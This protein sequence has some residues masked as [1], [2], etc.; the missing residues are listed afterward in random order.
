MNRKEKA[1]RHLN[2]NGQ[3]IEIGPGP[4][5]IAS[6]KEGY[7]V[8][9][10]DYLDRK[11]LITKFKEYHVNLDNIEEVD[12]IW[13]GENYAELTGKSKYYD[14][15]IAS[16]TIE[17]T[18]DLIDFLNDCDSI[19][20]DDGMIF[21]VI[22]DKRYCFDHYRPI[23][24]ISKII[25]SHFQK[26]KMHTPGTVAEFFLNHASKAGS[27]AW[28]SIATGKYKFSYSLENALEGIRSVINDKVYIDVHAW[29]FVPHSFRLIIHDLFYLKFIPFQ[30]VEFFPTEGHEFCIILSRNGKGIE[31]SR[32]ETLDIIESEIKDDVSISDLTPK[33]L[34]SKIKNIIKRLTPRAHG[35]G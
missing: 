19:L 8:H 6:K 5:P 14:W 24:G 18:P 30:E 1:F 17:H 9:I 15:I 21:L 16:H 35:R 3:G 25:D 33:A 34:V 27:I 13:R 20:K 29:C 12:F 22:P 26:N 11:N 28:D 4:N 31:K 2:P 10:I 32:L 7:K 23:T